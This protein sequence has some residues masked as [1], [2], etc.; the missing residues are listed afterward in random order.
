MRKRTKRKVYA[1]HLSGLEIVAIRNSKPDPDTTQVVL[2]VLFQ[3]IEDLRVGRMTRTS[4]DQ[5]AHAI[6]A[7]RLLALDKDLG[8]EYMP[9]L[10]AARD[11]LVAIGRRAVANSDRFVAKAEELKIL[12]EF[13][14]LHE[15]Q[16]EAATTGD[17]YDVAKRE[18]ELIRTGRLFTVKP[19]DNE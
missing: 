12:R 4:W 14:E 13:A 10:D 16:L 11:A 7:A 19:G 17:T 2:T 6:N 3:S 1:T 5:V 8:K 15:A 9:L 18:A